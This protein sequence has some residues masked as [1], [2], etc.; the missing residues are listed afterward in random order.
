MLMSLFSLLVKLTK[1]LLTDWR[2]VSRATVASFIASIIALMW[3]SIKKLN[4][5]S[6]LRAK[7]FAPAAK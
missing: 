7:S 2:T 3:F 1:V 6:N 4:C 5:F